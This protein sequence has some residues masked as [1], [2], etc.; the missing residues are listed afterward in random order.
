[1]KYASELIEYSDSVA[2]LYNSGTKRQIG[3]SEP[4]QIT[5]PTYNYWKP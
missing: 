1:M 3:E 5:L 2:M 4:K